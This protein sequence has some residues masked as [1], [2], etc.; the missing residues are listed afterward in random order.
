MKDTLKRKEKIKELIS[1]LN[2]EDD[3]PRVRKTLAE[4]YNIDFRQ[5][6]VEKQDPTNLKNTI[7]KSP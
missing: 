6:Q 1:V 4:F 2:M 3:H 7:H 5:D